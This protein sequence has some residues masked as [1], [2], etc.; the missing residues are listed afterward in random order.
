MLFLFRRISPRNDHGRANAAPRIL[1]RLKRPDGARYKLKSI[2]SV[3]LA[4]SLT[5]LTQ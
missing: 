2:G 3:S 5:T 4:A 1:P